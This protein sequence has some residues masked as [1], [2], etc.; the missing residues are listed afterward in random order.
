MICARALP[1]I[2]GCFYQMYF[3][4]CSFRNWQLLHIEIERSL[5]IA[6]NCTTACAALL[7]TM[8][9]S[10][11]R[12]GFGVVSSN[13]CV[14]HCFCPKL[15]LRI[16]FPDNEGTAASQ[17]GSQRTLIMWVVMAQWSMRRWVWTAVPA[18]E[19]GAAT[20]HAVQIWSSFTFLNYKLE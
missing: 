3:L 15:G 12:V 6:I 16:A 10:E 4:F 14:F 5:Y 9:K 8:S 17:A 7:Y 13:S 2:S 19:V 20:T 1:V 18:Q 11:V